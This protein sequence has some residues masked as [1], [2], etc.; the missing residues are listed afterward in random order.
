MFYHPGLNEFGE[1]MCESGYAKADAN[2]KHQVWQLRDAGM[3]GMK[4]LH[5][6]LQGP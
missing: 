4:R 2:N 5:F 6:F 3:G 1:Q